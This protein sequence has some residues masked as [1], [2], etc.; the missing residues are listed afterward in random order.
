MFSEEYLSKL[1]HLRETLQ[2]IEEEYSSF[3]MFL[4]KT[5]FSR[6]SDSLHILQHIEE[7]LDSFDMY[8][9][10]LRSKLS[11]FLETVRQ[12]GEEC[13]SLLIFSEKYMLSSKESDPLETMQWIK[14]EWGLS[15][16]LS[17]KYLSS[18]DG[19]KFLK[20]DFKFL[21]IILNLQVSKDEL[22]I[23]KIQSLFRGAAASLIKISGQER[24]WSQHFHGYISDLQD[25]FQQT[26]SDIRTPGIPFPV[27]SNTDGIV[28]PS[29]VM[30]FID[31]VAANLCDLLK[32][33]DPSSL[34]CIGD[35]M[36]QIEKALKELKFLKIFVCFVS[37][38]C[39]EPHVQQT[40]LTHALEV[41]W[42]TTMSTWLYLPRNKYKEP[43][44]APGEKYPLFSQLLEYEIQPIRPYICKI[45][46]DVLQGLKIVQS[47]WYPVLQIKY[48]VDREVGFMET[49][50]RNLEELPI[51]C[52]Y[53]AT[54]P[55]LL[56]AQL[57]E[58]QSHQSTSTGPSVS[59]SRYRRC[60]Y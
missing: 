48:V 28:N 54:W 38:R 21:D 4:Y 46:T 34:L 5:L 56:D 22:D 23:E 32:F 41:A 13:G 58:S 27:I 47:Q 12:V 39:I 49:L 19:L 51:S 9:N 14:K 60:D 53:K 2:R 55:T 52:N 37:D 17:E 26:K 40:S 31:I 57:L 25:K 35:L 20:R 59:S 30:E 29:F 45:Y 10:E 16:F 36:G 43:D 3:H 33:N 11:N 15:S 24:P 18:V 7:G 6:E 42:Q 8:L 50:L 1:S 44:L